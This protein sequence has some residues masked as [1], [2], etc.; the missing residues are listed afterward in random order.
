MYAV[1]ILRV[2]AAFRLVLIYELNAKL[3]TTV[4]KSVNDVNVLKKNIRQ[5]ETKR[6]KK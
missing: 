5:E 1:L 3:R 4:Y 6:S 2:Q